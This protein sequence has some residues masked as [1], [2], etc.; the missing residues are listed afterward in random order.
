MLRRNRVRFIND[1]NESRVGP[2]G[3]APPLAGERTRASV[4]SERNRVPLKRD[5][6]I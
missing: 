1:I 3:P 6:P 2:N 5:T 4:S